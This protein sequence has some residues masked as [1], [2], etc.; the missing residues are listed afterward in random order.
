MQRVCVSLHA[1]CALCGSQTRV[2]VG[3]P[4]ATTGCSATSGVR[5]GG[6]AAQVVLCQGEG[7]VAGW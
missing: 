4:D 1:C 6:C 3:G 2:D 5:G 7:G